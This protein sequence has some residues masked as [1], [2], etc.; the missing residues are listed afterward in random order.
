MLIPTNAHSTTGIVLCL[1]GQPIHRRSKCQ[2]VLAG[3]STEPEITAINFG[4]LNLKW[5]EML[6][7]SNAALSQADLGDALQ[8]E[9]QFSLL[10]PFTPYFPHLFSKVNLLVKYISVC[11]HLSFNFVYQ[12]FDSVN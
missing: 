3:N 5:I 1:H 8:L 4:A 9:L 2:T 11:E 10:P 12:P 6:T 7:R